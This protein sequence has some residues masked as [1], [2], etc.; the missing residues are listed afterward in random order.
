MTFDELPTGRLSFPCDEWK[1]GKFGINF[2]DAP[3]ALYV[4]THEDDGPIYAGISHDPWARWM[5]HRQ[6]YATYNGY[7]FVVLRWFRDWKSASSVERWIICFLRAAGYARGNRS[8]KQP[9]S[10]LGA[11]RATQWFTQGQSL[12]RRCY[13]PVALERSE[14]AS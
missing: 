1:E 12:S 11:V 3:T 8:P 7:R 6:Q 2:Y 5:T 13:L 10:V 4:I 9:D 14:G